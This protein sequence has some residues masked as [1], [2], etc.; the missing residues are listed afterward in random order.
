MHTFIL[1]RV[2]NNLLSNKMSGINLAS[3]A[4]QQRNVIQANNVFCTNN[5]AL[6][7][8]R[9]DLYKHFYCNTR[10]NRQAEIIDEVFAR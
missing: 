6:Y 9:V 5:N 3:V 8:K 2:I 7:T 4:L 1:V 10:Q